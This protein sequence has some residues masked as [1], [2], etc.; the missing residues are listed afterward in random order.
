MT[1]WTTE[2]VE[3]L[4]NHVD[5]MLEVE[6]QE[7]RLRILDGLAERI[8]FTLLPKTRADKLSV[9]D[10]FVD[11]NEAVLLKRDLLLDVEDQQLSIFAKWLLNVLKNVDVDTI[12]C[13]AD[14]QDTL[15]KINNLRFG[16]MDERIFELEMMVNNMIGVAEELQKDKSY[17]ETELSILKQ[18]IDCLEQDFDA[19]VSN[20]NYAVEQLSDTICDLNDRLDSKEQLS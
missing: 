16:V 6:K 12:T 4:G 13:E 20:S 14:R 17:L 5:Y 3:R 19:Y 2:R 11:C 1:K 8:F 18:N 9:K 7:D 10:F 15:Q